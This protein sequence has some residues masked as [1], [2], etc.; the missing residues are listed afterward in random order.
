MIR[1]AW[2]GVKRDDDYVLFW[3]GLNWMVGAYLVK[4]L[5]S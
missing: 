3:V 2:I 5:N 1:V 4:P